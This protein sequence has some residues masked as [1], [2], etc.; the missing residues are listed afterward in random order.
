MFEQEGARG[1][2]QAGSLEQSRKARLPLADCLDFTS[3]QLHVLLC[4]SELTAPQ[5]RTTKEPLNWTS[6]ILTLRQKQGGENRTRP[7]HTHE[8]NPPFRSPKCCPTTR[9]RA[10][11]EDANRTD[12]NNRSRYPYLPHHF[13][14]THRNGVHITLTDAVNLLTRA[15]AHSTHP[16][17][18]GHF[19]RRISNNYDQRHLWQV[20]HQI[21]TQDNHTIHHRIHSISCKKRSSFCLASR[22]TRR[23]TSRRTFSSSYK[24]SST[25]THS[26]SQFLR[27]QLRTRKFNFNST[28]TGTKLPSANQIPTS[29]FRLRRH[30]NLTWH[31]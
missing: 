2:V 29:P 1:A 25:S 8:R 13:L 23:R 28:L 14:H 11:S 21:L 30:L 6:S 15:G 16:L 7:L 27:T 20:P 17:D 10:S 19:T 24:A 5:Y 4:V 26:R 31:T 18:F 3:S 22:A 12:D 9:T